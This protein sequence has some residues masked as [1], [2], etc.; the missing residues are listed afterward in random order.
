MIPKKVLAAPLD[1]HL[2]TRG[3]REDASL[4]KIPTAETALIRVQPDMLAAV[5]NG[6]PCILILMVACTMGHS[7]LLLEMEGHSTTLGRTTDYLSQTYHNT[8]IV[9]GHNSVLLV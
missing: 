7:I 2:E 6:W 3:S 1:H 4:Q 5:S 9:H 8:L